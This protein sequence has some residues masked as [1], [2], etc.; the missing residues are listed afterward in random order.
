MIPHEDYNKLYYGIEPLQ[1]DEEIHIGGYR[2]YGR[3]DVFHA[4]SGLELTKHR[5]TILYND[6][7][8][9]LTDGKVLELGS[10]TGITVEDFRELGVDCEGVEWS[11]YLQDFI[12]ANVRP[13]IH[14]ASAV[15]HLMSVPDGHYKSIF[16]LRFLPCLTDDEVTA[17]LTLAAAKSEYQIYIVDD[18]DS[19]PDDETRERLTDCYNIKTLE[20]WQAICGEIP[21]ISIL[22]ERFQ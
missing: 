13:Y 20:Q 5:N 17:L 2:G 6:Y 16:G 15:D 9:Y 4:E 11:D 8:E 3:I 19:Y 12:P 7:Q 10:A 21:C 18:Y 14:H 22:D 1:G